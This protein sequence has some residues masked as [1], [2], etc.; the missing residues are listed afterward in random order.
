L[1]NLSNI[2]KNYRTTAIAVQRIVTN[3]SL[4]NFEIEGKTIY[5]TI[6]MNALA[7]AISRI[8]RNFKINKS[9]S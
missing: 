3:Q 7:Q 5:L 4:K 2:L 1:S 6:S 9:V 8:F